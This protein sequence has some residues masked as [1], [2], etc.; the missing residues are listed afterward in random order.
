LEVLEEYYSNV[1]SNSTK[2]DD[3]GETTVMEVQQIVVVSSNVS[4][5]NDSDLANV[6]IVEQIGKNSK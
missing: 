5:S 2:E 1:T 6:T 4:T 3:L